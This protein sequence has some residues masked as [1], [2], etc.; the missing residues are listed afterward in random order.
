MNPHH[1]DTNPDPA[2]TVPTAGPPSV[3]EVADLLARL[4][5]L[6]TNR[7]TDGDT[8]RAERARFLTDKAAL[9]ARIPTTDGGR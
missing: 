9:L 7:H 3:R 8:D 1:P 4:R 5:R 2:A 6:S